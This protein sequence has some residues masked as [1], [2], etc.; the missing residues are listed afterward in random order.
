MATQGKSTRAA[1]DSIGYY[2]NVALSLEVM[3]ATI[4]WLGL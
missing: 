4:V 3:A 2:G 1:L